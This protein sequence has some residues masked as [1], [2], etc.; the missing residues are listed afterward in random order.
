VPE[1]EV[2]GCIFVGNPTYF[3]DPV[4]QG[5]TLCGTGDVCR[6]LPTSIPVGTLHLAGTDPE[7]DLEPQPG[8]IYYTTENYPGLLQPGDLVT[9]SG[10]GVEDVPAFEISARGVPELTM[11]WESLTAVEHEQMVV[12]WDVAEDSPAGAQVVL[13]MDSDHH[14]ARAYVECW[15]DDTGQLVV[16]AAV[17]DPLILA[18]ETGIGTYIENAWL[19]RRHR[20]TLDTDDGC[21]VLHTEFNINIPVETVR[22]E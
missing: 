22:D 12:T 7:L 10:G 1:L 6:P 11:P 19:A 4:C 14:G 13:H 18:G 9:V 8:D 15:A 20:A 16:P 17:I 21:A 3:C 5:N 2:D